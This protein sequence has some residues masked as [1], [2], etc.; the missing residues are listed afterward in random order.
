MCCIPIYPMQLLTPL[1][2]LALQSTATP[3]ASLET[4]SGLTI[5]PVKL[6]LAIK[7]KEVR[8]T[9]ILSGLFNASLE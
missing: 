8:T 4:T 2:Q 6:H 3:I 5:H 1:P 9:Q 7:S